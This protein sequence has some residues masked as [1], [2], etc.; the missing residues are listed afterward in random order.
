MPTFLNAPL[1]WGLAIV[2]APVIIHLINMLRHKRVKWAAMEF[3]LAGQRKHSSWIRLKEWLLLLLR[4]AAVAAIVLIVARPRL[5]GALGKRLG[6]VT[7]HHIVLLDDSFSMSD[8]F[9]DRNVFGEAK[10]AVER[11]ALEALGESSAQTFTLLRASQA[12]AS[13]GAAKLDVLQEVVNSQF[14]FKDRSDRKLNRVLEPLAP[15]ESSAGPEAALKGLS[16]ILKSGEGEER[17]L[18]IVSDFRAKDWRDAPELRNLLA[19]YE[20]RTAQMYF[21]DCTEAERPNLAVT[22]LG[23]KSG[24]VTAGVHFEMQVEVHNYGQATVEKAAVEIR[25]DGDT[26]GTIFLDPIPPGKSVVG[27][28]YSSFSDPGEHLI[29]VEL[30]ADSVDADNRRYSVL[31]LPAKMPVLIINGDAESTLAADLAW[32]LAPPGPISSGLAPQIQIPAFL[33]DAERNPL[34]AYWG[35]YLANVRELD[36]AAVRNLEAYVQ[37]GGGA[38]FVVGNKASAEFYNAALYRDGQ[39]LFPVPLLGEKQLFRDRE[40]KAFDIVGSAHPVFARFAD[41]RNTF[42]RDVTVDRY[43]GLPDEWNAEVAPEAPVVVAKLRNGAPL[44]VEKSF[45][46]GRVAALLT[47]P[48]APWSDWK[49]N[50]SFVITML[51]TQSYIAKRDE[52]GL[53]TRAVGSPLV[54]VFDPKEY[55]PNIGVLPPHAGLGGPATVEA[56]PTTEGLKLDYPA[57]QHAGYYRVELTKLDKTTELRHAAFNVDSAEGDL[58]RIGEPELTEKLDGVRF[59]YRKADRIQ[60]ADADASSSMISTAILYALIALLIGEQAL[61]YSCSYHPPREEVSR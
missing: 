56:K 61:A 27:K 47:S 32:A 26:G 6:D 31:N 13:Q 55:Q 46:R 57:T 41:E 8:R 25:S 29:S 33:N 35:I 44:V 11:I 18:Y 50:P 1:L 16:S 38:L 15:S 36:A 20:K 21:V 17:I 14:V 12:A 43:F 53:E 37:G 60:P 30:P 42:L 7:T 48:L 40:S 5:D 58:A 45:G 52:R 3:L 54:M 59:L 28:F 19:N 4:M 39:G 10:A 51:E 22:A 34:A 9:A 23:P 2:A 49:K 24:T